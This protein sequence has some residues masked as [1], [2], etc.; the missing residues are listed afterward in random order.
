MQPPCSLLKNASRL[1]P[2]HD[3]FRHVY[4]VIV[5]LYVLAFA[6][7]EIADLVSIYKK[8][9]TVTMGHVL[10]LYLTDFWNILDV[11]TVVLFVVAYVVWFSV[12]IIASNVSVKQKFIFPEVR[13]VSGCL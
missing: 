4:E 9:P 12:I 11:L 5:L 3:L 13:T 10:K 6:V 1:S 8:Y 2:Q 7:G